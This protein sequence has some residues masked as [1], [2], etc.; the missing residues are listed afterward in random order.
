[1]EITNITVSKTQKLNHALYNGGNYESSDH[2]V[3]LTAEVLENEDV[4][5]KEKALREIATE[6]LQ[7]ALEDEIT[8]FQGGLTAEKFYDYIRDFTA[9]RPID[10]E[11]YEK[12]NTRQ[13]AILQA[14]KRGKQMLKRDNNKNNE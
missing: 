6:M 14:I 8:S 7:K 4:L 2:F 10:A 11:T 13:K 3:S 5:Q 12:A 9:N 1:M